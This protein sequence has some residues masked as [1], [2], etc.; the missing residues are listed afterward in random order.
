MAKLAGTV[1]MITQWDFI[2]LPLFL[3]LTWIMSNRHGLADSAPELVRWYK[4]GLWA[5]VTGAIALG[6]IYQYYYGGGDT[7]AYYAGA[8]AV[9]RYILAEPI[10]AL[11]F[12]F[13]GGPED[14][15]Y[16][17]RYHRYWDYFFIFR[18]GAQEV[19]VIKIAGL[20]NFLGLNTYMGTAIWFA[21]LAYPGQWALFKVFHRHFPDATKQIAF[22]CLF[23][24]SVVFWGA[25]I[26][27]DTVT[28]SAV[29]WMVYAID[30]LLQGKGKIR[31]PLI[32]VIAGSLTATIK[33]YILIA[34]IPAAVVWIANTLKQQLPS[35]FLRTIMTPLLLGV[36]AIAGSLLIGRISESLGRYSLDRLEG[37]AT[38]TQEWHTV[39]SVD[40]SGY[41]LGDISFTPAGLASKLPAAVNVTLFRPYL[42]E[43]SGVVVILAALESLA[44]LLLTIRLLFTAGF[45][46]LQRG[47]SHPFLQF[48]LIF[49]V[50]LAFAAG[51]TSYN[52]GALMRYKIPLMP[53]Y[54]G[55]LFMMGWLAKKEGN[56]MGRRLE[57]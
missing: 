47:L 45:K 51:L 57:D 55:L 44:L 13:S 52:F 20:L 6:L 24:P 8:K 11:Q 38:A 40:G 23:V 25:G 29:G 49:T 15:G 14:L 26:L 36:A 12:L 22:A 27:K 34:F 32:L 18:S 9:T 54:V 28:F 19:P 39:V 48:A 17:Q 10:S 33:G 16:V 46:G 41:S 4:L 31:N 35:T 30:Q 7:I 56:E 50:T 43:A 21:V 3:L 2:F 53:F 5:K 1:M 37:V 42:W